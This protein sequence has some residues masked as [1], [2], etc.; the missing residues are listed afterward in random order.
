MQLNE[1]M[2][3]YIKKAYNVERGEDLTERWGGC[4][5]STTYLPTC[6]MTTGVTS[7]SL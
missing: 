5:F 7:C 4:F 1:N 3:Q 2:L 6:T